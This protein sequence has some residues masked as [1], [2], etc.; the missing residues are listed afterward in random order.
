[1][2]YI[3]NLFDLIYDKF[4]K[5]GLF[6]SNMTNYIELNTFLKINCLAQT[7]GQ[8]KLMIQEK[9]IKV[10]NEV[11]TRNKR[12]LRENDVVEFNGKKYTVES[13]VCLKED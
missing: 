8:A 10:N 9:N 6:F 1:M 11:E 3:V 12:K 5:N 13:S 2:I 4:K 7:G